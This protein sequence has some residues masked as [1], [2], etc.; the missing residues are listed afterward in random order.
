MCTNRLVLGGMRVYPRA[1]SLTVGADER[2]VRL[3][4]ATSGS[5]SGRWR[6]LLE[7]EAVRRELEQSHLPAID[8][9]VTR[10]SGLSG[11]HTSAR[12]A[13]SVL[14]STGKAS[15]VGLL[16]GLAIL[17]LTANGVE[18]PSKRVRPLV[19]F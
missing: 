17:S 14:L 2:G 6:A 16:G 11:S 19:V 15:H 12:P 18:E 8:A 1:G 7:N 13:K 3:D 5:R 10:W 9:T 4:V